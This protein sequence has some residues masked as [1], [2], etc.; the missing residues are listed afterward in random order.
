MDSLTPH[1]FRRLYELSP[2][3]AHRSHF[4]LRHAQVKTCFFIG[5]Q[6][7][8]TYVRNPKKLHSKTNFK[9]LCVRK[10]NDKLQSA[11][12]DFLSRRLA[13]LQGKMCTWT[14]AIF[15]IRNDCQRWNIYKTW[16][17]ISSIK[18]LCWKV[19]WFLRSYDT[20]LKEEMILNVSVFRRRWSLTMIFCGRVS[21][22][23]TCAAKALT[24]SVAFY[25]V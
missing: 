16:I 4:L 3:H 10:K 20:K 7:L 23:V 2:Q 18:L 11:A 24:S 14:K 12:G 6:N 9:T 5:R 25:R 21:R 15:D 19:A 22:V 8:P 17:S 13:K 1:T